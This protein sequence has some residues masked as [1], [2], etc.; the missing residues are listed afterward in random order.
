MLKTQVAKTQTN[1]FSTIIWCVLVVLTVVS[2]W[3]GETGMSGQKVMLS[4]L[5]ITM[6]KSQ[7]I[8]HYFIGLSKTRLLWR[9]MMF[10]YFVIVGGLIAIAYL[11][12]MRSH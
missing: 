11:I 2:F 3:L 1:N 6:I 10:F 4:L 12:G 7:L 9:G 5:V 8:A